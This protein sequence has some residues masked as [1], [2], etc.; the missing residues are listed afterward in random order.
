MGT[1]RGVDNQGVQDHNLAVLGRILPGS[2]GVDIHLGLIDDGGAHDL[3]PPALHEELV[4]LQGRPGRFQSGI[5]PG[6]PAD[7]G[8]APVL[9][10]DDVLIDLRHSGQVSGGSLGDNG[11]HRSPHRPST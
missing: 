4:P 10:G 9:A 5:H 2:L 6:L 1:L 7:V 11:F 3:F 8:A